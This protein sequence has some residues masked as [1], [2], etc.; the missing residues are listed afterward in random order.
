LVRFKLAYSS[1]GI[2]QREKMAMQTAVRLL[3]VDFEISEEK[4]PK[5]VP[6]GINQGQPKMSS[7]YA[8][9]LVLALDDL[10]SN[11][12]LAVVYQSAKPRRA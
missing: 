4:R 11:P 2:S 7:E 12:Y 1:I 5:R 6:A 3:T 9:A 8:I 10:V